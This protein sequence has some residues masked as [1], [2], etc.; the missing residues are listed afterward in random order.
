MNKMKKIMEAA[1]TLKF[2]VP[3]I[4]FESFEMLKGIALGSYQSN[5]PIIVQT[6]EPGIEALGLNNIVY[7]VNSYEDYYQIPL[8]LHLDHAQSITTVKRCIDAGYRSVMIDASELSLADNIVT[9]KEVTEYAHSKEAFVESEIGIVG[10]QGMNDKKTDIEAALEFVEKTSVDSLAVSVGNTHGGRAKTRRIDFGLL[11]DLNDII[12]IP[13]V[14]HG[15]SGIVDTDL[16]LVYKYGVCKV[17]IE[18]ELRLIY[19]TALEKYLAQNPD[20]IKVRNIN[21]YLEMCISNYVNNKC[22]LLNNINRNQI[23]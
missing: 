3:A 22:C 18:T 8:A 21:R 2:A 6:T 23:C 5:A 12:N 10:V 1:Y 7:M 15:S 17:N 4:N 14:L 9:T 16:S 19:R 11:S 13:L 20:D